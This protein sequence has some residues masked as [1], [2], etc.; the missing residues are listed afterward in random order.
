MPSSTWP[1]WE[2]SIQR[3]TEKRAHTGR[4]AQREHNAEQEG[5]EE[6]QIAVFHAVSAAAEEI[7]LQNAQIV[8]T[9][10]DDD[11]TGYKIQ[12]RLIL[13]EKAAQRAG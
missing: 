12:C 5:G 4:P 8:Q 11:Q 6:A 7:Q 2:A 10:Y 9:E 1:C 13:R 3:G